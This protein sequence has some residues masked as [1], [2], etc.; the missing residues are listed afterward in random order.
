[1][2]NKADQFNFRRT[3]SAETI[4]KDISLPL[5]SQRQ[6]EELTKSLTI[7]ADYNSGF[8]KIDKCRI[9]YLSEVK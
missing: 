3:S 1:M 6:I 9:L 7:M 2:E 8:G 4:V 5:I